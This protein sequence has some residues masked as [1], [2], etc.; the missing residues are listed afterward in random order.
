MLDSGDLI[1]SSAIVFCHLGL[2]DNL[3]I[4]FVWND[5][6]RCL[7][8]SRNALCPLGFSITDAGLRQNVFDSG[9]KIVPNQLAHRIA[10][11]GKWATQ[12]ALVQQHR[13]RNA[14]SSQRPNSLSTRLGIRLIETV[15]LI[16]PNIW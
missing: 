8:E 14:D 6:I 7:V 4:K 11:P 10:V 16:R 5:K 13:I 3:R 2:D 12:K 15:D 1:P 9:F